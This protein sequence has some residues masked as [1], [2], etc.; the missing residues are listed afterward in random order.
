MVLK[1]DDS[2]IRASHQTRCHTTVFMRAIQPRARAI[3]ANNPHSAGAAAGESLARA[4]FWS[5]RA[6][7]C[8][9]PPLIHLLQEALNACETQQQAAAP[10]PRLSL[11]S[12]PSGQ[13]SIPIPTGDDPMVLP[14]VLSP[15]L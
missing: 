12:I 9:A 15:D 4:P 1:S 8:P 10:A 14:V 13:S 2:I 5:W 3:A 11:Q 7:A 6:T